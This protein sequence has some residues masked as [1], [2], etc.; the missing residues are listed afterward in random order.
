MLSHFVTAGVL[1]RH[2]SVLER[3]QDGAE[4]L[5]LDWHMP[6]RDDPPA[7]VLIVFVL[8]DQRGGVAYALREVEIE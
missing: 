1:E 3:E 4:P 6:R 2:Y 8:R 5:L 7:R